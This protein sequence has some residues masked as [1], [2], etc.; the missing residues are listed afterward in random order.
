MADG[1]TKK[2]VEVIASGEK[3]GELR[4]AA[5]LVGGAVGTARD[6]G[7]VKTLV[8][9]LDDEQP[10]IRLAAI[11]A[12]GKM[13]ADTSLPRLVELVRQGG[14]EVEA[15]ARAAGQMGARGARAMEKAM[16]E[17]NSGLRRRIA[18]VLALGGTES[19]AVAAAHALVDDDPGVVDA[20]ARS[21]AAEIPQLSAGQRRSLTDYLLRSLHKRSKP[22][23]PSASEA[24]ML[25]VLSGL[26]DPRTE[27][28]YWLRLDPSRPPAVR[29]AALQAL[30]A[31]PS[32]K[33]TSQVPKLFRCAADADFQVAGSA[34]FLLKNLPVSRKNLREWL[35][36]LDARDVATRRLAV[37]K[38]DGQKDAAVVRGV[39]AQLTHPDRALR[40]QA[41]AFLGRSDAGRQAIVEAL[42]VASTPDEAW[43]LARNFA[44]LRPGRLRQR[45]RLFAQACRYLEE[46]DRLG[47]PL[48]FL[49]Q[50]TDH[51]WT[52]KQVEDR[53]VA[54]RKK[55]DYSGAL[56]YLRHLARD[57]ACSE[58]TRFELATTG[59]RL[60]THDLAADARG[61]DHALGQFARLLQ[62]PDF[63]LFAA[64]KKT[65]WLSE[66]DLFYL[67]F[68]F[69]EQ[70]RREKEFGGQVLQLLVQRS[71][72]SKVAKD[73]RSKLKSEGLL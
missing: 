7:L 21:L 69:A 18:S 55:R 39:A 20:A 27:A 5:I 64:V 9:A 67:G 26:H 65:K 48:L 61:A 72:R 14:P 53:A 12:L 46:G 23:L 10:R 34:L 66:E 60:S 35:K 38:L 4:H 30:G 22:P 50:Q 43:S 2:L 37:E 29:A 54:L 8:A 52:R 31:L 68:H 42:M 56:T 41:L 15:A 45:P 6:S 17:A 59:L 19:A 62:N 51:D 70:N 36:L 40:D 49:L 71:P 13:R 58:E 63:D 11:E 3:D 44:G 1:T 32:F 28:I 24:A 25:R 47:D 57:P 73:A 16:T 33:T